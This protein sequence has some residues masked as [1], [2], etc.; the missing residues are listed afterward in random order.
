MPLLTRDTPGGPVWVRPPFRPADYTA[1]AEAVHLF[2]RWQGDEQGTEAI[3]GSRESP[4][5]NYLEVE[6]TV[7]DGRTWIV[8]LEASR[9]FGVEVEVSLH[10]FGQVLPLAPERAYALAAARDPLRKR[11]VIREG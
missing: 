4:F 1:P 11:P 7:R 3:L 10:G 6:R 9:E 8:L 5:Q 2:A